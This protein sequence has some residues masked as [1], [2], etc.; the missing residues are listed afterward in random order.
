MESIFICNSTE[1]G[2]KSTLPSHNEHTTDHHQNFSSQVKSGD[3]TRIVV[4]IKGQMFREIALM[5]DT[6]RVAKI[7]VLPTPKLQRAMEK[8]LA[9]CPLNCQSDETDM[10]KEDSSQQAKRARTVSD[11]WCP[12]SFATPPS[13]E[14]SEPCRA[15]A[16]E[17]HRSTKIYCR[18]IA[19]F[20]V[21][22]GVAFFSNIGDR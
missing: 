10:G 2:G 13:K 20:R 11:R 7:M 6:V 1:Q 15:T 16:N 22:G 17:R 4:S 12:S 5:D 3:K 18:L 19:M 9:T 14:A 21:C 8:M